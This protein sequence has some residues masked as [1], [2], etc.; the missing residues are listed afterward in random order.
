MVALG[1]NIDYKII[2]DQSLSIIGSNS[3]NTAGDIYTVDIKLKITL[4]EQKRAKR[5][6]DV[7]VA[8]LC[9]LLSPLLIFLV[10]NRSGFLKN[11]FAVLSGKKSWVGYYIL[12]GSNVKQG[13]V[14][15]NQPALPAIK[16]GVLHP[17]PNFTHGIDNALM[18]ARLNFIYA[19]DYRVTDDLEIIISA[20]RKLGDQ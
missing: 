19:K 3:K 8:I 20:I 15:A 16:K 17:L 13:E 7:N 14:A 18:S 9:L 1:Q 12:R 5:L 2:P 4:P 11:I 10:K 6:L